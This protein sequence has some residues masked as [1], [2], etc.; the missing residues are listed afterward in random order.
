LFAIPPAA[1]FLGGQFAPFLAQPRALFGRQALESIAGF[2][3]A[4][5][6]LRGQGFEA[7][8]PL[9]DALLPL[10]RRGRALGIAIVVFVPIAA[11]L[12]CCP[13]GSAAPLVVGELEPANRCPGERGKGMR[14]GGALRLGA[15]LGPRQR[16][17]QP[18]Q[19]RG[20]WRT[21]RARSD[22]P[23]SISAG[24]LASQE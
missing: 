24:L 5:L 2:E 9:L 15:Q 21:G 6:L 10:R 19:E 12:L 23:G 3:Q 4:L 14:Q 13:P 18:Q 16:Q 7:P 11:A 20:E 17:Q 8:P 22:H 1:A